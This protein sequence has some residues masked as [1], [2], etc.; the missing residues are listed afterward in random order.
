MIKH[1]LYCLFLP[2]I[3]IIMNQTKTN[4]LIAV[5]LVVF[6]A[7]LKVATYPYSFNPIIAISLFSG[8]VIADK[9]LAFA[10]PLLAMFAADIMLEVSAIAPGF[11]GMEQIGNYAAL[12]LVTVLG[13]MM[14]KINPV[15][16]VGF[17]IA[18][19]LLFYILSNTNSFLFDSFNMYESGISGWV[20]CMV[21][22]LPFVKTGILT[23]LIFS[24]LFFGGHFL[25]FKGFAGKK[26][27][28]A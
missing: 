7:V 26:P 11:Y 27:V 3:I 21:A 15:N 8:A 1:T 23:D 6:A 14:K 20:K 2:E 22:G 13:F 9:K 19:S 12:L 25:A 24:V 28:K 18:S 10:M 16:V 5:V 17:S 4:I